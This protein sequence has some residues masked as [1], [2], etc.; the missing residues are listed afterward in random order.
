MISFC[1]YQFLADEQHNMI[2]TLQET[3]GALCALWIIDVLLSFNTF[4]DDDT[5]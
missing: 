1:V 5:P 3:R 2:G 4:L